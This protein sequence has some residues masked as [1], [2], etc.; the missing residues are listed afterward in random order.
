[1]QAS[2]YRCRL[3]PWLL[4]RPRLVT[5]GEIALNLSIYYAK[6]SEQVFKRAGNMPFIWV[7]SELQTRGIGGWYG[8]RGYAQG[9]PT[10]TRL[11]IQAARVSGRLADGHFLN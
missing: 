6:H 8:G 9:A 7:L 1:M 2:R 11:C 10:L 5:V 3:L 4:Q